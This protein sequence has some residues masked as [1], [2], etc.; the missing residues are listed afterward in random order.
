LKIEGVEGSIV[1]ALSDDGDDGTY[2][3]EWGI[4]VW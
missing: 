3:E 2:I 4:N 1:A